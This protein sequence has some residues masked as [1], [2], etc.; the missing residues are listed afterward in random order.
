MLAVATGLLLSPVTGWL[1]M[2]SDITGAGQLL[3]AGTAGRQAF[4]LDS[5]VTGS[6]GVFPGVALDATRRSVTAVTGLS[7]WHLVALAG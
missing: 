3:L 7:V 5:A 2:V 6:T 4:V 1:V